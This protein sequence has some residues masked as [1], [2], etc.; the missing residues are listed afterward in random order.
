MTSP[1]TT[2]VVNTIEAARPPSAARPAMLA[3]ISGLSAVVMWG[4]A[5]V[6]TRAAV[7]Q[8]APLPLTVLRALMAALVCLPWCVRGLRRLDRAELLRAIAGGL[9]GTVGYNVPVALGV[10]WLPASTAALVLATEPVCILLLARLFL[11][12]RTPRWAWAGSAVA[13]SGVAVIAGPEALPS[14]SG[15][16]ALEGIA[17][18]LLGTLLFGAYTIVLRPLSTTHGAGT[19]TAISTTIG[20]VPYL[21]FAGTLTPQRLTSIAPAAWGE[22]AFLALGTSVAGILLWNF[23]VARIDST[24]AGLLLFLEP[25]VGVT[26]GLVLLGEHLSSASLAGGAVL[27]AG[28]TIAWAAQ[29][30]AKMP[31]T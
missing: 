5:P 1:P 28:I 13:L 25:L 6:A 11:G 8:L 18:V 2:D 27:V 31:S 17:L 23:S 16:R 9:L 19:A 3:T 7:T 21:L 14:D 30:P 22:L 4:L 29:R 26:G 12:R 10:Q 20:A 24:R 15:T